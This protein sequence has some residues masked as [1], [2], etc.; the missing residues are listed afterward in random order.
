MSRK[1]ISLSIAPL[2]LIQSVSHGSCTGFGEEFVSACAYACVRV[3]R[4]KMGIHATHTRR[5]TS[6][7]LQRIDE[8]RRKE[9]KISTTNLR[10][11]RKMKKNQ[12]VCIPM[13]YGNLMKNMWKKVCNKNAFS[14]RPPPISQLS[15]RTFL[16]KCILMPIL[17][18]SMVFGF[19]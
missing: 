4:R 14:A 8:I 3:V 11:F 5:H 17:M 15:F 12:E 9:Q 19:E 16:S 6:D 2:Q 7:I 10:S 18:C 1:R 13:C